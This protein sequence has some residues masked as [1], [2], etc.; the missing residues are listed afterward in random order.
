M[1]GWFCDRGQEGRGLGEGSDGREQKHIRM[2]RVM[3]SLKPL[4]ASV[5]IDLTLFNGVV[6]QNSQSQL[7]AAQTPI[8]PGTCT[9]PQRRSQHQKKNQAQ[10]RVES[11]RVSIA[12]EMVFRTFVTT[13]IL[14]RRLGLIAFRPG[15]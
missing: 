11:N 8:P 12:K 6:K 2:R 13:D 5:S 1:R 3:R 14:G 15:R 9:G 4:R 7:C 10:S